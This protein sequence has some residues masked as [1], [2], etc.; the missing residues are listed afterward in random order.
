MARQIW[1]FVVLAIRSGIRDRVL[2]AILGVGLLLLLS[3][4]VVAVFSMRQVLALAVSYSLSVISLLGLLLSVFLASGVLSRD[5]ERR[6]IYT[7][8]SLPLSRTVYL[9]GRFFGFALLLF[10]ALAILS[11]LAAVAIFVLDLVHPPDVPFSWWNFSLALWF[12]YWIV[13]IVGAIAVALSGFATSTFL[14]LAL[15][16]GVYFAAFSTEAVKYYTES[17]LGRTQT[18]P[19]IRWL[20]QG[21]Y[22]LLPNF[23]AFDLKA[24]AIYSLVLDHRALL[25]TQLYGVGYLAV[26]LAVAAMIFARREFL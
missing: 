23:S 11:V 3:I 13:L 21:A 10:V 18:A 26:L 14:P 19:I 25:L 7:V 16:V 12:Q 24:H 15:S 2:H 6:T 4:P 5:L 17:P 20:A 22:W 8:C 1:A 9:L